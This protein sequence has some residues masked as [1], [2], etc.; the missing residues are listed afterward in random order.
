MKI[1]QRQLNEM[2]KHSI[3]KTLSEKHLHNGLVEAIKMSLTFNEK[4]FDFILDSKDLL[5]DIVKE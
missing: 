5:K 4:L 3:L 1:S 2:I